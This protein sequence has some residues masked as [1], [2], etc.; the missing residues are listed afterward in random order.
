MELFMVTGWVM[1]PMIWPTDVA[2]V[3]R[4]RMALIIR[5]PIPYV[6]RTENKYEWATLSNASLKSM[7]RR[8]TGS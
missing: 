8:H 4:L 1:K 3:Y 7:D 6:S 2:S 5:G